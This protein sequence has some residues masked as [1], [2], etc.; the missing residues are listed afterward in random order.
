M[1]GHQ[2][3][4]MIHVSRLN[5]EN[6][7]KLFLGF[8]VGT[9]SGCDFAVLPIQGQGGF[10]RLKRFPTSP[11]PVGAKM[12]IIFKACVVHSVSLAL[13]QAVEFAFVVVT[14]TDVF[15]QFLRCFSDSA[16]RS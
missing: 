12:V 13:A 16:T 2:L 11:V 1:L 4:G 7:S 8:R 3:Y 14:Q 9:V 15:Y 10:R 5:D 6:A